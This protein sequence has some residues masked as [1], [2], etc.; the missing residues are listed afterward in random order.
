MALEVPDWA[1]LWGTVG[2][3]SP[4]LYVGMKMVS[5]FGKLPVLAATVDN[6]ADGFG[7]GRPSLFVLRVH[8]P[9]PAELAS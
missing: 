8:K 2:A 4:H 7:H 6:S 9:G 1:G 5:E 3:A